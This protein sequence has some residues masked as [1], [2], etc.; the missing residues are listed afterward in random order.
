VRPPLN[1]G[2]ISAMSL[3]RRQLLL[4]GAAGLALAGC[5]AAAVL[6]RRHRAVER[7]LPGVPTTDGAGVRL[8][9][10]I[11]HGALRHL[12]PFVMLDRFHSDDPSAYLRGFPDHPHRGFE[13]VTVMLDGRMR[14]RD[15]R[16][17]GGVVQGG[18]AQ[19]MTAGRGI[20]HSEM[21]EQQ[22]GLMSGYQLWINLPA[23]EKLCPAGYEEVAPERIGA[24]SLGAGGSL[25]VVAGDWDGLRGPLQPRAT[26]PLLA[27]LSLEDDRELHCDVAEGHNMFVH[28]S[29]GVL[30]LGP[31]GN[32]VRV[33]AGSLAILSDGNRLRLRAPE[34]R[35]QLLVAAARPLREPIVQRGPFVMNTEA[36]I[37]QAIDDYQRGVLDRG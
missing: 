8:T 9:R 33:E 24:A 3:T 6:E 23:A 32:P 18:G 15:T 27:H 30:E 11:G 20:I 10:L 34:R 21:P 5:R 7:L 12:D 31:A 16:G 36:E 4:S 28:V 17:G 14:H 2:I 26:R 22:G 1:P 25:R 19:W 13:T 35:T 37:R 29:E